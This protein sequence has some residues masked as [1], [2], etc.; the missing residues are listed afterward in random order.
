[1]ANALRKKET[2]SKKTYTSVKD[3][4]IEIWRLKLFLCQLS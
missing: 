4:G 3:V 2:R 1:M